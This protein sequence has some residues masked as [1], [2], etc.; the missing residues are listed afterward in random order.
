[1]FGVV[2]GQLSSMDPPAEVTSCRGFAAPNAMT[3]GARG[4]RN[5]RMAKMFAANR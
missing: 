4:Y 2:L 3:F 5:G 1:M